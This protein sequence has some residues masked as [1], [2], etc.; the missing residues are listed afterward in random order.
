MVL[1]FFG[2]AL[3]ATTSSR[4]EVKPMR[5]QVDDLQEALGIIHAPDRSKVCNIGPGR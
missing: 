4:L 2:D 1:L 3:D 5:Q